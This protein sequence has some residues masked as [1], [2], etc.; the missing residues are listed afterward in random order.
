MAP[1]FDVNTIVIGV[2]SIVT[3]AIGVIVA[4]SFVYKISQCPNELK[5]NGDPERKVI[6]AKIQALG[7]AIAQGARSFLIKEYTYL[8]ICVALLFVL[9]AAA[10][11]WRTGLW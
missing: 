1:A 6:N 4:M 5:D 8:T 9:V 11:N 3:A 7:T 10:V 2:P